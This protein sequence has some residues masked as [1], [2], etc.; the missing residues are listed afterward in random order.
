MSQIFDH[1]ISHYGW[2]GLALAG[3]V[4]LHYLYYAE[5]DEKNDENYAI[6]T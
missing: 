6:E 5:A 3:S 1:I 2:Q 4:L